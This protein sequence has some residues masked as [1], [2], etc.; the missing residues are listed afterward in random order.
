MCRNKKDKWRD[1]IV[2]TIL[3]EIKKQ[4]LDV[5]KVSAEAGHHNNFISKLTSGNKKNLSNDE[6]EPIAKVLGYEL[7]EFL[8]L[9]KEKKTA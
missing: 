4:Q 3:E 5:T 7:L 1:A 6:L 8:E 2:N 9:A